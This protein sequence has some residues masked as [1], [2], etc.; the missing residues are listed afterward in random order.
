MM[1][2][3]SVNRAIVIASARLV[4]CAIAETVRDTSSSTHKPSSQVNAYVLRTLPVAIARSANLV[5]H[6]SE[7]RVEVS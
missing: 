4:S 5:T 2:K 6:S 7:Q 1:N 3:A